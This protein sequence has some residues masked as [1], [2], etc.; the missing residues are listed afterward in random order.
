MLIS[1]LIISSI[2][3][4]NAI[5]FVGENTMSTPSTVSLAEL[6]KSSEQK[7]AFETLSKLEEYSESEILEKIILPLIRNHQ[8]ILWFADKDVAATQEAP[9][10]SFRPGWTQ[11]L[12]NNKLIN[13]ISSNSGKYIELE[14][15]LSSI[16]FFH[17]FYE[18]TPKAY[19]TFVSK[20]K[21]EE[22]LSKDAFDELHRLAR[23]V[24]ADEKSYYA[25]VLMLIVSDLGKT[26]IVMEAARTRHLS[27]PD[28]DDFIENLLSQPKETITAIIPSFA[29]VP[30]ETQSLITKVASAMKVHLGH[31][32]HLE[33]GQ[34]LFFKFEE[35]VK[36][37]KISKEVLDFAFLI[38]MCDVA[39]A[40]AQVNKEGSL[41]LIN[42]TYLGYRLVGETLKSI[43]S[44]K[45]KK[46]A[47]QNYLQERG[48]L[49]GIS[50]EPPFK[51][52]IIR[53]CCM[54][55][56][57][58]KEE[59]DDLLTVA[60]KLSEE[61]VA[62]LTEQLGVEDKECGINCWERNPTYVPAVLLNLAKFQDQTEPRLNKMQR[63]LN[64][65]LCVAKLCHQY[66]KVPTNVAS[67]TPLNFNALAGLANAN[68]SLFNPESFKPEL[69]TFE[70]SN[71]TLK[72]ASEESSASRSGAV[73]SAATSPPSYSLSKPMPSTTSVSSSTSVGATSEV[74][75]AGVMPAFASL[76][77]SSLS[78][79]ALAAATTAANAATSASSSASATSDSA[80][81]NVASG[82]DVTS[83]A[84]VG[85]KKSANL[86]T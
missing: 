41:S 57:Y 43:Q 70:N 49:V 30:E 65:A 55:R 28:H 54:L 34:S 52:V 51:R 21:K 62:L 11:A 77:A 23:R 80:H 42:N 63:A 36:V 6:K 47:L 46:E 85:G 9:G 69:F 17:L 44:G 61:S 48:K 45:T 24:A 39:A 86:S 50:A 29:K 82:T 75:S 68:P 76:G 71:V 67:E 33:G 15:M 64:G 72:K 60:A 37:G 16:V 73:L 78:L 32:L 83:G 81:S 25:V 74:P 14:R 8:E 3:Y 22:Q 12:V 5:L 18:G 38:Q 13:P 7:E 19:E 56:L 84:D 40:A 58:S 53:L 35:A 4:L 20:Q 10:Q 1:K 66:A 2:F 79:S 59:A 26:P 27:Q 31:V